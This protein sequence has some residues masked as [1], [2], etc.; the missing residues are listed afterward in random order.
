MARGADSPPSG[1]ACVALFL[2]DQF[3]HF[4]SIKPLACTLAIADSLI[5]DSVRKLLAGGSAVTSSC[6]SSIEVPQEA[7]AG[8]TP[9][10]GDDDA[11]VAAGAN[12]AGA[13]ALRTSADCDIASSNGATRHKPATAASAAALR[14]AEED[15]PTA[16][17]SRSATDL[18]AASLHV[19][20]ARPG[21]TVPSRW[22]SG[23]SQAAALSIDG[24]VPAHG[25]LACDRQC[26]QVHT[27]DSHREVFSNELEQQPAADADAFNTYVKQNAVKPLPGAA[28]LV[29][30]VHAT[31]VS[32]QQHYSQASALGLYPL[33]EEPVAAQ[34]TIAAGE[35]LPP[36]YAAAQHSTPRPSVSHEA[37]RDALQHLGPQLAAQAGLPTAD[38]GSARPPKAAEASGYT[39]SAV[40]SFADFR[41]AT[42]KLRAECGSNAAAAPLRVHTHS[43]PKS[44]AAASANADQ[45]ASEEAS[46]SSE[47]WFPVSASTIDRSRVSDVA[48]PGKVVQ[49]LRAKGSRCMLRSHDIHVGLEDFS[50]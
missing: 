15:A 24:G 36:G 11:P 49:V 5:S 8:R 31:S 29:I 40:Q 19:S 25:G 2:V 6:A 48:S 47:M 10:A 42:A 35:D 27:L 33:D 30:S 46:D 17:P 23:L 41:A 38:H 22:E 43:A 44:G 37:T 50:Y 21:A 32:E 3:S 34:H 39:A 14:A 18:S 20:S 28:G 13:Q 1:I 12:G 7:G 45:Q 4:I 9:A 16:A 26:G